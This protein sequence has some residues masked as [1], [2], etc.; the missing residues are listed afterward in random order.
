[1]NQVDYQTYDLLMLNIL[2]LL[3]LLDYISKKKFNLFLTERRT[4]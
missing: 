4:F 3:L 1:M 2:L